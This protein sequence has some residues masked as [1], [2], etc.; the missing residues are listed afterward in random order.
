LPQT[1]RTFRIFVSS[2]FSDLVAERNALQAWVFPRLRELA[3]AYGCRFQAIDLRWGVSE[4]AALD[5]QALTICLRE[6]ERCQQVSP[7]PNFLV[8]LG[9]RYGWCPPPPQCPAD[10][11]ERMLQG[12]SDP[13]QAMLL[14]WYRRDD[15][16]VPPVYLLL[17]RERSGSYAAKEAWEPAEARL[18]AILAGAARRAGIGRRRLLKYVASA[19]HQEI[20]AGAL[21][22]DAQ[23]GQAFCFFRTIDGLPRDARAGHYRDLAASG[24]VDEGA[25]ERLQALEQELRQRLPGWCVRSYA[26]SWQ[27]GTL[28]SSHLDLLCEQVYLCFSRAIREQVGDQAQ[29]REDR[30]LVAQETDA[31]RRFGQDRARDFTG[32]ETLLARIRDYVAGGDPHP[33]AVWGTGGA[34]KSAVLARAAEETPPGAEVICR[35][36][37][38]T[39]ESSEALSLVRG[40]AL[41]VSRRYA[42]P[43]WNGEATVPRTYRELVDDLPIR[44]RLA[45]ASAQRPLVLFVDALDQLAARS[46]GESLAACLAWLPRTLPP[47]V[48]L[49]VSAAAGD[50]VAVLREKLPPHSMVELEP[51]PGQEGSELLDRWLAGA[52]RTLRPEQRAAV[53]DR[54]AGSGQ[55]LPLYLRLAFEEARRWRSFDPPAA[56]RLG[57]DLGEAVQGLFDRLSDAAN[58][59]PLLVSRALGYLAAARQGLTED[60]LLDLLAR[61]EELYAGF[62]QSV[63]HFPPDLLR[64][65]A[66]ALQG[67]IGV[68]PEGGSDP[69]GS[70]A[71]LAAASWIRSQR[72]AG[73]PLAALVRQIVPEDGKLALPV[74]LWSR[75]YHELA[76]YL[77]LRSGDGTVLLTY[78]HRQIE[79]AAS[80]AYL[81]A[82]S[83]QARHRD[84]ARYFAG[85]S[86]SLSDGEHVIPNQRKLSELL[87]QQVR[88][89]DR[90]GVEAVLTDYEFLR[91]RVQA[92]GPHRLIDDMAD[93]FE[94]GYDTPPARLVQ[95]ALR[96]AAP[97][98]ASDP[99]QMAQQVAGR[100]LHSDLPAIHRLV[101]QIRRNRPLLQAPSSSLEQAGGALLS[102]MT[103]HQGDVTGLALTPDGR[104]A[105]TAS[106]DRT[107]RVWHL[108]RGRQESALV[109]HAQGVTGVL[110]TPDG[111]RVVS[112]GRDETVRVWSLASA[113][114]L[115]HVRSPIAEHDGIELEPQ[116]LYALFTSHEGDRKV[117]DLESG[118]VVLNLNPGATGLAFT[119]DGRRLVGVLGDLAPVVWVLRAAGGPDR[120]EGRQPEIGSGHAAKI[121]RLA[122]SPCGRFAVSTD[123]AG[124]WRR[125]ELPDCS[126]A[127]VAWLVECD[128]TQGPPGGLVGAISPDGR[129][130]LGRSGEDR[131]LVWDL[132]ER[133]FSVLAGPPKAR[134]A[135]FYR[136]MTRTP[137]GLREGHF[138]TV[139]RPWTITPDGRWTIARSGHG[140]LHVWDLDS[141]SER[142]TLEGH[143]RE[144]YCLAIT[145]DGRRAVSTAG[146]RDDKSIRVW[147]LE[148]GQ[149]LAVYGETSGFVERLLL[150]PDGRRMVTQHHDRSIKVWDLTAC[151]GQAEGATT[152]PHTPGP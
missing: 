14:Q 3:A 53:L 31:H 143:T 136:P 120:P 112:A 15:N 45:M 29:P 110:V 91:L 111:C 104:R 151:G 127:G 67:S 80:G 148:T 96:L 77:S 113:T 19:T 1:G 27:D 11:F 87:T 86:W 73:V 28:S 2:T 89:G 152:L 64:Y 125:W 57:H 116:G 133:V 42:R 134:F 9:D 12:I 92:A 69:A 95:S 150:T 146:G 131:L 145:P 103:G 25:Q 72:S 65:A 18:Q 10:E 75:L 16:A 114:E 141:G 41:E 130:A 102:V 99:S 4:E 98:L 109:G 121:N 36:V 79:E 105:V 43:F 33:L 47:H 39:P 24:Q 7:R 40:I 5:Q 22:P 8:L 81:P 66:R 88:A 34:G 30:D 115:R 61:D 52:G 149:A 90:E 84:L 144:V 82:E 20:A 97:V 126:G 93:A 129:R 37:G 48:R 135:G 32:R 78:Y 124:V 44:L 13:E 137:D 17:P 118:Q 74:V 100:L 71:F 21:A 108:E 51:M 94:A 101:A 128:Q 62:L 38:A 56:T 142:L 139:Y 35:F 23:P 140:P 59:G 83:R 107:L 58:H 26:A 63:Y 117:F 46:E 132:A 119:P 60:E 123:E 68:T 55:G 76:P 50:T 138:M 85:Q 106:D 147:D 6:I 54:F 70:G 49:V 122:V